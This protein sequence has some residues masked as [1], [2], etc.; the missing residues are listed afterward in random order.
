M[1]VS[2]RR[3]TSNKVRT[4]F[5]LTCT[6]DA[7]PPAFIFQWFRNGT[8]LSNDYHNIR[9]SET[10]QEG[11]TLTSSEMAIRNTQS[12]DPCDYK[13]VAV[14]IYGTGSAVFNYTLSRKYKCVSHSFVRFNCLILHIHLTKWGL[15]SNIQIKLIS[16]KPSY[17]Y[18]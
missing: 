2:S 10:I 11:E 16:I 9:L 4:G 7:N 1:S 8:K 6:S 17:I 15:L 12:K 5:V 13:C 3:L 18:Q 14:S